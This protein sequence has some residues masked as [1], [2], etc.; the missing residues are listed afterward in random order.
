[1]NRNQQQRQALVKIAKILNSEDIV[2][3]VGA[4]MLLRQ[5]AL[6]DPAD[7][8]IVVALEDA[9]RVDS[10]L[11]SLGTVKNQKEKSDIY[12][13][14][15]F[16]EYIIDSVEIDVMAGFKIKL[17]DSSV[18]EYKFDKE[19]IPHIFDIDG[20]GVP[21]MS[22][23]DW[24]V[25]YQLMPNREYKANLLQD[26]FN[27]IGV[28]YPYL[29]ERFLVDTSL[30]MGVKKRIEEILNGSNKYQEIG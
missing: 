14:D 7:I 17:P 29:L 24:Y 27:I 15:F 30:P 5:Y 16:H 6:A 18:F 22:L 10:L 2:W 12:L 20:V 11:S 13:T 8:D 28:D 3:A 25:L 9:G 26:H 23:E 1:M 21:F 19:S 4:S